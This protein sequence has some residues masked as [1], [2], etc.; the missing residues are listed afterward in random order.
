M[1][2]QYP[3][4]EIQI[5]NEEDYSPIKLG[6]D[7]SRALSYCL[8]DKIQAVSI[9]AKAGTGKSVVLR[10]LSKK[11]NV[12][13]LA[14]TGLA[15]VNVQGETVQGFF[16]YGVQ[17][18]LAVA[19]PIQN[20]FK[21]YLLSKC[22]IIAIDEISMVRADL[23]DA[24]DVSCRKTLGS[25][26]PFGGKKIVMIGDPL[27]LEPV[28]VKGDDEDWLM[29][30]YKSPFFFDSRVY[31]KIRN[32]K[33]IELRQVF[34]QTDPQ[35]IEALDMAREGDRDCL[36]YFNQHIL[37]DHL[38]PFAKLT[39]CL[40]NK[41]AVYINDHSLSQIPGEEYLSVAEMYGS[42]KPSDCPGE[43]LLRIK[44]GARVIM[45]TNVPDAYA[46]GDTGYVVKV[47]VDSVDVW[48][49]RKEKVFNV[50]KHRWKKVRQVYNKETETIETIESGAF[51]QYPMKLA[52]AI[53]SHKSQGQTYKECHIC[54]D[55]NPWAHGQMYVALSRCAEPGGLSI[56]RE[57]RPSDLIVNKRV[58][59]W[60]RKWS[61][62]LHE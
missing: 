6:E 61:Q 47:N 3:E 4:E 39:V 44:Q 35:M 55:R 52:W 23:L 45:L 51:V 26:D 12:V 50:K 7:Q 10:E 43:E 25:D 33:E 13:K 58:S 1:S 22:D 18:P 59:D 60:R 57:L 15:A 16:E 11:A 27:Q 30:L 54:I 31:E 2:N 49:D 32:K 38:R 37:P 21:S 9:L 48:I 40:T 41:A 53:T 36:P 46:N 56:G 8:D 62:S 42:F 14:P 19:G 29:S 17:N 5:L 34:R 24:I 20:D 28:V